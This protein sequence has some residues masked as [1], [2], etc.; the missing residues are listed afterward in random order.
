MA[1]TKISA[2]PAVTVAADTDEYAT[3]QGGVSKKTTRGT[4]LTDATLHETFG[5]DGDLTPAQITA[6]QNDYNP[7]GLDTA[8]ILR[9]DAD[10]IREITGIAGGV[11]GRLLVIRN[12]GAGADS[13]IIFRRE[14]AGS[15]AA[16]RFSFSEDQIIDPLGKII[17][18]YDGATSRWK[19]ISSP[20]TTGA[21]FRQ[22][23]AASTDFIG[24]AGATTN[25]SAF[26]WDYAVVS[27]GTQSKIS[28]EAHHPGIL[29][30]TS[31]TTTNSGGYCCTDTLAFLIGGG[32]VSEHI[33]RLP[34]LTTL[35]ARLGFQD[36]ITSTDATDGCY[37]EILSTGVVTGKTAN[38][39]TRTTSATIA[40]LSANTWYRGRIEVNDTATSVL[41]TIFD[42]N[43]NQLGQ[44]TVTTNIPTGT[45][46]TCGHGYV[47]TKSGTVAQACIDMDFM[48]F[49]I[50]KALIR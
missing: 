16:N 31:S 6:N 25:E 34:D 12:I 2:L 26:P 4:L 19:L 28:G 5:F 8:A 39:G 18:Q 13:S 20:P 15:V 11:D 45:G 17:I 1:D 36:T 32:E 23:V 38:N 3:N 27:G 21:T 43:G 37:F 44:Q 22:L 7:S 42:A 35:T 49:E 30:T 47:A 50:D 24:P 10:Q 29:R 40:T 46:R 48:S 9:L 33:F 14:N 41:F